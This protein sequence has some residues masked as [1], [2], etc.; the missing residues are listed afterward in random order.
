[1]QKPK[2]QPTEM[3]VHP[4]ADIFPMLDEAQ[5]AG[6][7]QSIATNGQRFPIMLWRNGAAEDILIDGRNRKAACA[8]VEIEPTFDYFEGDEDDVIAYIADVNLERRDLTK[9]Q[10][11]MALAK[12]YPQP[13]TKGQRSPALLEKLKQLSKSLSTA[14][15][16]LSQAR[17]ILPYDDLA[18]AVLNGVMGLD[19]ANNEAKKRKFKSES[20]A[21]QMAELQANAPEIA[22]LVSSKKL[23]FSQAWAAYQKK[24]TDDKELLKILIET[25]HKT[26]TQAASGLW[27]LATGKVTHEEF[28]VALENEDFL[29]DID[30][31][32]RLGGMGLNWD[33]VDD[34]AFR[35]GT[36]RLIE[37]IHAI[38]EKKY[39]KATPTD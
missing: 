14:Q 16:R 18:K 33:F 13:D 32:S 4:A 26:I 19:E 27:G 36:E 5:L 6:L 7:A 34:D 28:P 31:Y 20:E 37:M 24:L 17:Q 15:G 12:L 22:V 30:G 29:R 21:D 8:L 25:Q 9:A 10:K 39:G 3:K 35:R 11:V 23:P 38:K 1:M 2:S